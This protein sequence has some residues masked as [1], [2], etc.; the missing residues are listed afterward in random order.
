MFLI[1]IFEQFS[2]AHNKP[3]GLI[4]KDP[5]L[6]IEILLESL[7]LKDLSCII[8]MID[9]ILDMLKLSVYLSQE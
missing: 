6:G 2:F 8:Y 4:S 7:N 1:I 3:N 5:V 9:F